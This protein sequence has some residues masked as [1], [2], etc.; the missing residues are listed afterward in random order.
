MALIFDQLR[1]FFVAKEKIS[2]AFLFG[3][4]ATG[5]ELAESDVDV[6]VWFDGKYTLKE[7]DQLWLEIETCIHRE[8]DLIVLNQ[9]RPTVAW[10]ALRGKPLS[11]KNYRLYLNKMLDF[12]REAEDFQNFIFDFWNLRRKIRGA[13]A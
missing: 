8:V 3:S 10:A 5:K 1:S 11:I 6:A 2:M 9:A 13:L 4:V 7:V 12:S